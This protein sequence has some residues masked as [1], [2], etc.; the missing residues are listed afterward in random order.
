[1]N[2]RF[3]SQ[4]EDVVSRFEHGCRLISRETEGRSLNLNLGFG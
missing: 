1:M 3:F 4:R 2:F